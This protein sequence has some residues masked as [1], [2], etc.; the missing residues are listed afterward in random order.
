MVYSTQTWSRHRLLISLQSGLQ[1]SRGSS[2]PSESPKGAGIGPLHPHLLHHLCTAPTVPPYFTPD[3]DATNSR[4][5][6]L[7][8]AGGSLR[9]LGI[10]QLPQGE[11]CE[12]IGRPTRLGAYILLCCVLH[13]GQD[14]GTC[15]RADTG[16]AVIL[17]DSRRLS[18]H[19]VIFAQLS[20]VDQEDRRWWAIKKT[21]V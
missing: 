6:P 9:L 1:E 16:G 12:S 11:P 10:F 17:S 14:L 20:Q 18:Y 4:R 3:S 5:D 15:A 19:R 2:A 8:H 7:P 21:L 13:S